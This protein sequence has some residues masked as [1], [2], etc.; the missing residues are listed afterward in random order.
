VDFAWFTAEEVAR[1]IPTSH[2]VGARQAVPEALAHRLARH[3]FVDI[4]R[5]QSPSWRPQHV[6]EATL[7]TEITASTDTTSTLRIQG[8]IHLQAAGT[9]RVGAPDETGPS[10]QERGMIL[11][12]TG[13]ATYDRANSRFARFQAI[14]LGDRWGGTR[15]NARGRDLGKSPIGFALTLASDD[16]RV[17]PASIWAYGW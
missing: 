2:E 7:V 4:V 17:P 15:Y 8:Q 14:A 5:G 13:E 12:L 6:R 3:H 10:D 9:W 1:F 16:E 11:T